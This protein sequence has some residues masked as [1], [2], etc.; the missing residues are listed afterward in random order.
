MLLSGCGTEMDDLAR[1]DFLSSTTRI[2]ELET[3]PSWPTLR[4]ESLVNQVYP[5]VYLDARN[6]AIFHLQLRLIAYVIVPVHEAL[7]H[8][9][10]YS[11]W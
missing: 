7:Q 3:L 5:H 10:T 1:L 4:V 2:K 6:E 11:K 9:G 8:P